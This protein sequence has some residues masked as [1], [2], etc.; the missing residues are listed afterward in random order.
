[1]FKGSRKH[2]VLFALH[3][4]DCISSVPA[5]I[6]VDSGCGVC[7]LCAE[8]A[9]SNSFSMFCFEI[10]SLLRLYLQRS[11]SHCK[12]LTRFYNRVVFFGFFLINPRFSSSFLTFLIVSVT[13][14]QRKA[15]VTFPACVGV[16]VRS[17]YVDRCPGADKSPLMAKKQP[18]NC[19]PT[20]PT[21]S[22]LFLWLRM[23]A[24]V[25]WTVDITHTDIRGHSTVGHLRLILLYIRSTL[26][27]DIVVKHNKSCYV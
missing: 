13:Y 2:T 21:C 18:S 9:Y 27:I 19:L 25:A 5:W 8:R 20:D 14:A 12:T 24:T 10:P 6:R 17:T 4:N 22:L 3:S 11:I 23:K 7:L 1:M 26:N 15:A 16:S